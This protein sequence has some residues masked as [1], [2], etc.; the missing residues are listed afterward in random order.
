MP[1][2]RDTTKT[3][4]AHAVVEMRATAESPLMWLVSL[5]RSSKNAAAITTGTA[6][7]RGAQLKATATAKAPKPTWDRPSPIME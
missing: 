7:A 2:R 4:T 3:P 1:R 5:T 6:K